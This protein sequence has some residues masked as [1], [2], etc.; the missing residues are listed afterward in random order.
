MG[1]GARYHVSMLTRR[2]LV[3][4]LVLFLAL[5][6]AAQ[7]AAELEKIASSAFPPDAPGA[8]VLVMKGGKPLLR[9]GYGM[10]DLEQGTKITPESVFRI[11]SIT[12]QFTA[13]AVLQLIESGKM[14]LSDPIT[15]FIPDYPTQGKTITIA[16][17]LTHTSGIQSYTN[18]PDFRTMMRRDLTPEELIATFR[19]D[20][21]QFEP[22][23][24]WFYNNS[25]YILLGSIIEKVS[26]MSYAAYLE[27][28]VFARAGLKHTFYGDV[29]P[30]IAG[31]VP[32][33]G[34]DGKGFVNARYLSMTLPYAA[35]ALLS[36]VDDLARWNAALAAGKVVD[37]RLLDQA[38]TSYKLTDGEETGYGFGWNI[39]ALSGERVIEHGGGINGYA[40]FALWMPDR[41]VYVAVLS[42][43]E[44]PQQDP[45][46]VASLLALQAIGKPWSP[47]AIAM[48]PAELAAYTGV[49][50]VDEK[51]TRT[52]TV[53][54]G[55]LH[56]QRS[57][58]SRLTLLPVGK[59]SFV[60]EESFTRMTF[61]RDAA[62]KIV[63]MILD[64]R[65][66]KTRAPRV[67]E[68]P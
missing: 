29:A 24:Q 3:L 46:Y 19:S 33:Y 61:E 31:R 18:K 54:D 11:G 38:W 67:E 22:G 59:D 47:K 57:G 2:L 36:T 40:S 48:T 60:F 13:V 68:K 27:K 65:G 34:R 63:A 35:G 32:G 43:L 37:R 55:Q 17:L 52:L 42:N 10:A 53:E 1:E 12:K 23:A 7:A 25:A 8:A 58:G 62:G 49:Y 9:A 28:N 20:P 30:I 39:G 15:K 41:D 26:G 50:R 56:S 14:A 16:H 45:E 64:E 21:M 6:L 4:V 66:A 5:P 51:T 44:S